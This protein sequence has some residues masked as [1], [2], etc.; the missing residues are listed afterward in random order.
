MIVINLFAGPGCGKSTLASY[1]F[2]LLKKDGYNAELVT[3]YAKEL[4][5]EENFDKLSD[6]L[7]VTS[8]QNRKLSRLKNKVD[9]VVTDCPLL[10]G[11]HYATPEYIG[12]H[13]EPMVYS[14]FETYNNFNIFLE[15]V[16]PYHKVGRTQTE[17]EARNIDKSIKKILDEHNYKYITTEG[18]SVGIDKIYKDIVSLLEE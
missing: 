18:S 12:G 3:E 1:I 17:D 16:K 7:Y 10:L 2:Y 15:R 8:K 9:I 5:W 4:T 13:F 14:L 11:I 6:Q